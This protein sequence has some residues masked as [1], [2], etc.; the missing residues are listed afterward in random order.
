[1]SKIMTGGGFCAAFVKAF[2]VVWCCVWFHG[3]SKNACQPPFQGTPASTVSVGD[4]FEQ[5]CQ[6]L[7]D[8]GAD[9]YTFV[10]GYTIANIDP[11]CE[12]V[13]RYYHLADGFNLT[14]SGRRPVRPGAA[15]KPAFTVDNL[16]VSDSS[17]KRSFK[18]EYD[19]AVTR[20]VFEHKGR[21][22][23][24]GLPAT[25]LCLHLP[26][27]EARRRLEARKWTT[28]KFQD[29]KPIPWYGYGN[30]NPPSDISPADGWE[31]YC[32]DG[33]ELYLRFRNSFLEGIV[34]RPVSPMEKRRELA[35]ARDGANYKDA[36]I[37]YQVFDIA[38]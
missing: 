29:F 22:R 33:F 32:A 18:A 38:R 27:A 2:C 24:E 7:A 35:R 9:D 28:K 1:M 23:L 26:E 21:T 25:T 19:F 36:F 31:C 30:S 34:C 12:V 17:A 8:S 14:L 6:V 37:A 10:C 5:A 3:C 13:A 16:S 4:D 15:S 11:A 20:L